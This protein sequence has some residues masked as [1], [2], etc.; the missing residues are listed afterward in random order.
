LAE[1]ANEYYGAVDGDDPLPFDLGAFD[2]DGTLL[3]RELAIT[4]SSVGALRGLR[5][6]GVRLVVAT[7][8]RF[9]TAREHAG[10][11]GFSG[12]EPLVCYGG[13]MVRR[14]D[15]RTLL[16]HTLERALTVEILRWAE[17]RGLS[18]RLLTDGEILLP[19]RQHTALE[20]L[21]ARKEP[22]VR[23]VGDLV[24]WT[25]EAGETPTRVVI[26]D[27]PDRVEE[28]LGEA[29]DAFAGR[30]FVARSLP[31]YV[32]I[33]A[34]EGTKSRALSF[35]CGEWGIEPPRVAA[36]GDADNDADMLRFAGLG[37]AVGG[38]TEEVRLAADA[39]A[40]PVEED[41]VA[42]FLKELLDGRGAR[43]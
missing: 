11:L 1:G 12:E 38:A 39:F 35:L 19:P 41:G 20:S 36:F 3:D 25:E 17:E 9:E 29:R 8:R 6:F 34:L 15:G 30:A 28:W 23:V 37:V 26:V 13:S 32:E 24:K 10:R 5:G 16:H 4:E 2:L 21:R 27:R 7:G 31:H 14:M 33:G 42:R 18:A 22:G 40:P 43:V